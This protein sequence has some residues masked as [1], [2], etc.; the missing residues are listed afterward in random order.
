VTGLSNDNPFRGNQLIQDTIGEEREDD[1]QD[2]SFYGDPENIQ[3]MPLHPASEEKLLDCD[4]DA[5]AENKNLE[6]LY[7]GE[8]V[9]PPRFDDRQHIHEGGESEAEDAEEEDE[10]EEEEEAGLRHNFVSHELVFTSEPVSEV[11][12][13]RHL[14]STILMQNESGRQ[15]DHRQ[16]IEVGDEEGEEEQELVAQ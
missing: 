1:Y 12:N 9:S 16:I 13:H 6:A 10:E 2:Q 7:D 14:E 4:F 8:G 3:E 15:T 5:E 11:E